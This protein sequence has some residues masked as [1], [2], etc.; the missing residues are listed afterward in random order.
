M[1]SVFWTIHFMAVAL[2]GFYGL[3]PFFANKLKKA[4]P[5]AQEGVLSTMIVGNRIAQYIL[6]VQFITGGY[7]MTKAGVTHVWMGVVTVLLLAMFAFSG[8]MGKKMKVALQAAKNN[9]TDT[10]SISK[11]VTFSSIV[12]VLFIGMLVLM[13]N[14]SII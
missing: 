13:Q 4:A 14:S 12:F 6:V 3:A 7:M 2:I 9:Q 11:I 1:A 10:A 5:G 8:I